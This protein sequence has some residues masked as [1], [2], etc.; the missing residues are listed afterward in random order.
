MIV[1]GIRS[2][3]NAAS[4]SFEKK[5]DKRERVVSSS[6]TRSNSI[7]PRLADLLVVYTVLLIVCAGLTAACFSLLHAIGQS[8][9]FYLAMAPGDENVSHIR[10]ASFRESDGA[11][12]LLSGDYF[13]LESP[14]DLPPPFTIRTRIGIH[15]RIGFDIL[16]ARAGKAQLRFCF[17][18]TEA[19]LNGLFLDSGNSV[20]KIAGYESQGKNNDLL[21]HFT[22]TET[23][24]E[25]DVNGRKFSGDLPGKREWRPQWRIIAESS[26]K[27]G[28]SRLCAHVH[29]AEISVSGNSV[30]ERMSTGGGFGGEKARL[31]M[32]LPPAPDPCSRG[33]ALLALVI[34]FAAAFLAD[35]VTLLVFRF[36]P[37]GSVSSN[38][39]LFLALPI[40]GAILLSF[41]GMLVLPRIMALVVIASLALAR[42]TGVLIE[43]SRGTGEYRLRDEVLQPVFK[44]VPVILSAII[45]WFYLSSKTG[46]PYL[47]AVVSGLLPG[48]YLFAERVD[49]SF[50]KVVPI[51]AVLFVFASLAASPF[52]GQDLLPAAIM[53]A[54]GILLLLHLMQTARSAKLSI[55]PGILLTLICMAAAF[56]TGVRTNTYL[57]K[58]FRKEQQARNNLDP[59]PGGGFAI[60][61]PASGRTE[62]SGRWHSLQ[63]DPGLARIVCLGSSSTQGSGA[64]DPVLK[65]YPARL[66]ALLEEQHRIEADV[67]NGGIGGIRFHT[68][69]RFLENHLLPY[70]PDIVIVYFGNNGD[71]PALGAYFRRID[72][73]R[74]NN[75]YL[76]S[77]EKL[78]AA[79]RLA[80]GIRNHFTVGI[81]LALSELRTWNMAIAGVHRFVA[82]ADGWFGH[83]QVKEN[84][85]GSSLPG[86]NEKTKSSTER[87]VELCVQQGMDVVLVPE[88]CMNRRPYVD[89][90]N[91]AAQAH[92]GKG[93][94]FLSL[95][96]AFPTERKIDCMVDGVHMN[97][98]GYSIIA[99]EIAS[100]LVRQGLVRPR[101]PAADPDSPV[102][103]AGFDYDFKTL[104]EKL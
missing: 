95:E 92:A 27:P 12:I 82:F 18:H 60:D 45:L 49:R 83:R 59:I 40:L 76:D 26:E 93:V 69:V 98:E 41:S 7:R 101:V 79:T 42:I 23:V 102:D 86:D 15:S 8:N 100:F 71:D 3:G 53:L 104:A 11:L 2:A 54:L 89:E 5:M 80:P 81:Y 91:D 10:D 32:H 37:P 78:W 96:E 55:V 50:S 77:N 72:E 63:K 64:S 73:I 90:F 29:L 67:I 4:R 84:H 30:E 9:S 28:L 46:A 103:S 62:F 75:P 36:L 20:E 70:E 94:Y 68:L 88:I 65:S 38:E 44:L 52:T 14:P 99:E 61:G 58:E 13:S 66:E 16:F 57:E 97:D 87:I 74:E 21:I 19:A 47:A 24:V 85:A 56:E 31:N 35:A 48:S 6:S 17:S 43:Y 39:I 33:F 1:P 25:V 22:L 34:I 51:A